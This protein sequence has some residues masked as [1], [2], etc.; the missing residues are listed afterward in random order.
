MHTVLDILPFAL[1]DPVLLFL[2]PATCQ[3][4]DPNE[5]PSQA[6]CL[7]SLFSGIWFS[8]TS[9][10]HEQ[11][12]EG[13]KR[14]LL[15]YLFTLPAPFLTASGF[16][17]ATAPTRRPLFHSHTGRPRSSNRLPNIVTEGVLP[18]ILLVFTPAHDSSVNSPFFGFPWITFEYH[19]NDAEIGTKNDPRKQTLKN[20]CM[21]DECLD[22]LPVEGGDGELVTRHRDI[23]TTQI[24]SHGVTGRSID[25]GQ[26]ARR[27]RG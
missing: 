22:H 4:A 8:T 18:H 7:P 6:A 5:P 14:E 21:F 10:R 3:K 12:T 16:S 19:V 13:R 23:M 27:P 11:E 25:S 17:K 9:A 20:E 15:R 2:D 26:D 24:S 1:P